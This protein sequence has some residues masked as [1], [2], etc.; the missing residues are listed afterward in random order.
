MSNTSS[1]HPPELHEPAKIWN[2]AYIS[3]FFTNMAMNMGM[4]MNNS[5]LSLFANYLG[6]SES[7]IGLV[8]GIF[9]VSSI[10]F[11]FVSAPIID[12]YNRKYIVAFATVMLAVAFF[13]FSISVNITMLIAFRLLQGCGMAFGNA[14]CLA[15]VSEIIPK[16]KYASGIGYYSLAQVVCQAIGPSVGLALVD[17]VGFPATYLIDACLFL[18]ATFLAVRL[19]TSF[20]RTRKLK[21]TFNNVIAKEALLPSAVIS[22][23]TMGMVS[24]GSFL[25]LFAK[26]QG[27][28]SNIGWYFTVNA[29]T[30]LLARP[31]I[32]NLV[33]KFGL[34]KITIPALF[35]NIVSFYIISASSTLFTFLLA[36][37]ISAFGYGACGPAMQALAM[38]SVPNER[39][40]AASSTYYIGMD[41]GILIGSTI[42]GGIAE[43][44]G[45]VAM[46]HIMP[47]FFA[48]SI[49]LIVFF[50][51]TVTRIEA[52]FMA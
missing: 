10:T 29:V 21:L 33:D 12:T 25:I 40:G 14:C 19:K 32:G 51:K 38:K 37:F 6:A 8:M 27:V 34:I 47:A 36:A 2:K 49:S 42:S 4:F 20:K 22:V 43:A 24:V 13:G 39:R 44:F 11:R 46:W 7:Q 9:A 30:I 23:L 50:R 26:E 28:T 5:L 41:M 35:C 3:L 15:M 45:Y 18:I 1:E 16:D 52:D 31:L 17:W 48:I